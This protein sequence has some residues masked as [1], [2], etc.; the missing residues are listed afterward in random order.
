MKTTQQ[1]LEKKGYDNNEINDLINYGTTVSPD[2]LDMQVREE[3]G[4]GGEPLHLWEAYYI[5]D[6]NESVLEAK[7]KE[8]NTDV[9]GLLHLMDIRLNAL[10]EDIPEKA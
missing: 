10:C 1:I 4:L 2:G 7:A 3:F 8:F 9:K 6:A 5:G